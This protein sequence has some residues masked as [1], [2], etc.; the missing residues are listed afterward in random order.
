MKYTLKFIFS[1]T[2]VLTSFLASAQEPTKKDSIAPKKERYGLRVG[3]D[4]YKLTRSFYDKNY[5]GSE[6]VGD[7]RVTRRHYLAA[8]LGN[9]NSTVDNP[10]LNF[11]T[12]GSYIKV[13]FDYNAYQNWAGM[14]NMIY[15]GL[16][17]GVS[18]FSQTL[19]TYNI[20]NSHPYFGQIPTQI[21]DQKFSGLSAQ[22]IE[23]VAGVKVEVINNV[24]IGFSV[25]LKDLISNNKPDNFDNLYIPGFSRTYAG[26][27][28]AGFNYTLSYF[29]PLYKSTVKQKK[30]K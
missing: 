13:G 3:A 11:T 19:N 5:K 2:L 21:A 14:E 9:E 17:Y 7:F 25:R 20:Y 1:L 29:I 8:E 28:G 22:W 27:F 23:V 10:H 15:V 30:A 16:R 6:I 24:Y 26:N 4:L 12:K 18:S